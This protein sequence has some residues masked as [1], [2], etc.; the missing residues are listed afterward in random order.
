[1]S[2]IK[3]IVF[4]YGNV[5]GYFDHRRTAEK[6]APFSSR[7]SEQILEYLYPQEL[8]DDF[9]NGSLSAH[10]FLRVVRDQLRLQCPA[11]TIRAAIADIFWLNVDVCALIPQ[12][13]PNY[14]LI[15]GSNTNAIHS[16]HFRKL[17]ADVLKHFHGQVLSHE[18]EVRKPARAF[19]DHCV[20]LAEQPASACLFIDDL[21]SN[22][23]G[24]Q[25]AGLQTLLYRSQP[26][27]AAELQELGVKL[28]G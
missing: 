9:E 5:V 13:A 3:A 23:A 15:L 12:L 28:S 10:D 22:I 21:P 4:D 11:A 26:T 18:V 27:L 14:R 25:D 20:R 7:S 2:A 24:A 17:S 8:E 16:E 1:M 19:F 6:L